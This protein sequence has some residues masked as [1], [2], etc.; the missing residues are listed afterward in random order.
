MGAPAAAQPLGFEPEPCK[1][2]V[3]MC[4]QESGENTH[5]AFMEREDPWFNIK[6][7]A[8]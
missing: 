7:S 5:E 8:T 2:D 6:V 3:P 4:E 1:S